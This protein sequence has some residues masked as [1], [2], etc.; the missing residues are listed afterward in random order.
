MKKLISVILSLLCVFTAVALVGCDPQSNEPGDESGNEYNII[1]TIGT[2][3]PVL[4]ALDCINNGNETYAFIERGKT[5]NG[6]DNVSGFNNIGFDKSNNASTG[7]TNANFDAVV[8]KIKDLNVNGNEKFNF[9]VCDYA[10]LWGFGLAASAELKKDQY[11]IVLCENGGKTYEGL[12]SDYITDK[13]VDSSADEPYEKFLNDITTVKSKIATVL[14]KNKHKVNFDIGYDLAYPA[15]T[16]SNVRYLIQDKVSIKNHLEKSG[17]ENY[18]TKLLSVFGFEENSKIRINFD[19]GSISERVE[20][21]QPAQKENYLKL[22]YGEYFEDTHSTLTR[23]K[24]SDNVTEVPAEK[25]VFIGSRANAYPHIAQYFGYDDVTDARQVP[26]SYADLRD[27]YKTDFLFAEE[28]D[29]RLFIDVLKDATNYENDELPE[30]ELLDAIR[31]ACF[32][33]YIDYLVTLKFT[34]L[35]YGKDYDIVLKGH[36]SEVLGEHETWTQHYDVSVNEKDYRYDKLYDNLLSAFHAKDS[37]G[38]CIGL[39]PFGTAAEN[40]AY[41]GV[42]ISLCGLSSGTY[43]GYEQSVDIKFVMATVNDAIDSDTNISGRY[44]NGT[45]LDHDKNGNETITAFFNIG[46][47]YKQLI[48]YYS[49]EEH[50][51][52]DYKAYYE[53]KFKA[54]LRAVNNLDEN[55]DTTGY[56][57]D[58]QGFLITPDD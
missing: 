19:F 25:L 4:A 15:A 24:L 2:I 52:N 56:D 38:K 16:L 49:S 45:L 11:Q 9:Y 33:Y 35:K 26:D 27:M 13:T 32:N 36:P 57:V 44:A 37:I 30:Q 50:G 17:S 22:M 14:S 1:F 10:V 21:L 31:V 48:Q 46:N 5:Y 43:T 39:I 12:D 23:T 6:I 53:E 55:A 8:K 51:N 34:Y 40:L 42:D 18:K 20:R 29:Y 47:L 7:F 58:N 54:W 28:E 41:L 3:P